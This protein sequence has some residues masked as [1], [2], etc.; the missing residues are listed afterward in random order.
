MRRRPNL[1]AAVGRLAAR[2]VRFFSLGADAQYVGHSRV[3]CLLFLEAKAQVP[4]L[5]ARTRSTSATSSVGVRPITLCSNL[6]VRSDRI[7]RRIA[8]LVAERIP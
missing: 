2:R 7:D 1:A 6:R 8:E 5:A 3:R 4:G